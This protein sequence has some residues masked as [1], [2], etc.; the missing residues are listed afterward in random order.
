MEAVE[1]NEGSPMIASAGA[2][3]STL[4]TM[5]FCTIAFRASLESRLKD[6]EHQ[7]EILRDLDEALFAHEVKIRGLEMEEIRIATPPVDGMASLEEWSPSID[8]ERGLPRSN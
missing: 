3:A 7:I 4:M 1:I 2:M 5:I 8:D 6:L